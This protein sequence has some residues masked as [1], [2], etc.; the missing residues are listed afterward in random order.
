LK[1]ENNQQSFKEFCTTIKQIDASFLMSMQ[2]ENADASRRV[3][4]MKK[5]GRRLAGGLELCS[6]HS[7]D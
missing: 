1:E 7:L 2:E 5:R 6:H 4:E 3:K